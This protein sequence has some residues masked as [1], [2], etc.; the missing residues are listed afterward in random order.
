MVVSGFRLSCES[1][2]MDRPFV[3]L[4][5]EAG[6]VVSLHDRPAG[7]VHFT[8]AP[9]VSGYRFVVAIYKRP[10]NPRECKL[11]FEQSPARMAHSFL[12]SGP[13]NP[14]TCK[15]TVSQFESSGSG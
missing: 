8:G 15:G 11:A 10:S 1:S 14:A 2:G 9:H 6:A 5:R 13:K 12:A 7:V 4:S 3:A